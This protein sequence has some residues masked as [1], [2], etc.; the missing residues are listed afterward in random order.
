LGLYRY[1]ITASKTGYLDEAGYCLMTRVKTKDD[2]LIIITFNAK[3]RSSSFS[4]TEELLRYG[5]NQLQ[6]AQYTAA[7]F[8]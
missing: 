6:Q 5:L 4:E 8:K 1:P 2:N 7:A 3:D